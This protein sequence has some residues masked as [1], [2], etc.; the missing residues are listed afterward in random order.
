MLISQPDA[1][2]L[3]NYCSQFNNWLSHNIVV[4]ILQSLG[5]QLCPTDLTGLQNKLTVLARD[6]QKH[7]EEYEI[8]E[9]DFALFKRVLLH[10]K[11]KIHED[12]ETLLE[13]AIDLTI[14]ENIE[15]MTIVVDRLLA[16]S[17]LSRI[18][19]LQIPPITEFLTLKAAYP[20]LPFLN[21]T[22]P[23]PMFDEKFG[24][25]QAPGTFLPALERYRNEAWVRNAGVAVAFID[26]DNFKAFN[27]KYTETTV[28]RLILP[29]VMQTLESHVFSHGY[30]YRFGGDEY[31]LLLPNISQEFAATFLHNLQGRLKDLKIRGVSESVSVSIGLCNVSAESFATNREILDAANRA[32]NFA[33]ASGK[34]CIATYP[35]TENTANSLFIVERNK[36]GAYA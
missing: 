8:K 5:K 24:I 19:P 21:A 33:K 31:V 26:I 12:Q 25:L 11:R 15:Q 27:T 29:R 2:E 10:Q 3:A 22:P 14:Q 9:T 18:E 4:P 23:A 7:S 13:K 32:K 17:E 28:D 16:T 20:V 6:F 36:A 35:D 1:Q 30:A 34:D